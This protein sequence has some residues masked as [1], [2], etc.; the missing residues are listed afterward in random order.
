[1]VGLDGGEYKVCDMDNRGRDR[2]PSHIHSHFSFYNHDHHLSL[3]LT[4]SLYLP[5]NYL[6]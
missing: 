1:M 6:C 2:V 3:T 5:I 4:Q